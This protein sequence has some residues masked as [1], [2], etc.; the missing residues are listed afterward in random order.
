MFLPIVVGSLSSRPDKHPLGVM[1][2][3]LLTWLISLRLHAQT[4]LCS[5]GQ[6]GRI[7]SV[8]G[9]SWY[10]S[11]VRALGTCRELGDHCSCYQCFLAKVLA[12]L[13][14]VLRNM[15]K[16]HNNDCPKCKHGTQTVRNISPDH[17]RVGLNDFEKKLSKKDYFDWY[18][19]MPIYK[20]TGV[21]ESF[22][23]VN[24][25]HFLLFVA[26][27]LWPSNNICFLTFTSQAGPFSSSS[28]LLLLWFTIN[29][30]LHPSMFTWPWSF[31]CWSL[32][33][34]IWM[35]TSFRVG[36]Q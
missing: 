27:P 23:S 8:Q 18:C 12:Q 11:V 36:P 16:R 2:C 3:S 26:P 15:N 1:I 7:L 21:I 33:V 29:R 4:C 20:P 30:L 5:P 14:F 19:D 22:Y 6:R 17:L 24:S 25:L 34:K 35:I 31:Q 10:G 28:H 32:G 9:L 13:N